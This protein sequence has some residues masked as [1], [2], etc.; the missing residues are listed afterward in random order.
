[1]KSMGYFLRR[2]CFLNI[3]IVLVK[4]GECMLEPDCFSFPQS[5]VDTPGVGRGKMEV[6][7]C[8]SGLEI[9]FEV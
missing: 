2:R 4:V 6:L 5:L 1:M 9:G 7:E 3:Q 8:V